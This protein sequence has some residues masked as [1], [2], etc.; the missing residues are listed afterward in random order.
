MLL[1][2]I[3]RWWQRRHPLI[4]AP[5]RTPMLAFR[6]YAAHRRGSIGL[7]MYMSRIPAD[8]ISSSFANGMDAWPQEKIYWEGDD[9]Q[10][11]REGK[12]ITSSG[13]CH[14][15]KE[16]LHV[17]SRCRR[18]LARRPISEMAFEEWNRPLPMPDHHLIICLVCDCQL[19]RK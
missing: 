4:P 10:W 3:R 8:I 2:V 16:P 18:S 17:F 1:T 6:E 14:T 7:K 12:L 15:A 19:Y 13:I 11:R 5:D 9:C